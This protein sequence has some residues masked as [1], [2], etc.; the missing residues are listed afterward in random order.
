MSPLVHDKILKASEERNP[1]AYSEGIAIE[2]AVCRSFGVSFGLAYDR[3]NSGPGPKLQRDFKSWMSGLERCLSNF[4]QI[5][6]L[7]IC[8]RSPLPHRQQVSQR[9]LRHLRYHRPC[10]NGLQ[11]PEFQRCFDRRARGPDTAVLYERDGQVSKPVG[12]DRRP[13][14]ILQ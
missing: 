9:R 5:A 13:S 3:S 8:R 2:L 1:Y 11:L 12:Y 10:I 14:E 6:E 4:E 7:R